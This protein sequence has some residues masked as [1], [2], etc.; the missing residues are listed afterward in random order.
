M[1]N[2]YNELERLNQLK[3]N[4]TITETEFEIEKYKILNLKYTNV[5]TKKNKS[6]LFFILSSIGVGISIVLGVI[7][8]MWQSTLWF[9]FWVENNKNMSAVNTI[10]NMLIGI[11]VLFGVSTIV[12]LILA[13][14]FKIK[15]KGGV[16][17]VD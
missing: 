13:V 12:L 11:L 4:G 16:K 6:K 7:Y 9:D 14:I 3:A 10:S 17:I 8:Y 5:H 15:E 1:E 2:K